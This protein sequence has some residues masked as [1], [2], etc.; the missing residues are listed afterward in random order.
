M[1]SKTQNFSLV[2]RKNTNVVVVS[3]KKKTNRKII[4]VT[5]KSSLLYK[6][7]GIVVCVFILCAAILVTQRNEINNLDA[8]NREL[9]MELK[10]V[11]DLNDEYERKLEPT[12][13]ELEKAGLYASYHEMV[14]ANTVP[15]A[16]VS[17]RPF[18][19]ANE[20]P[21]TGGGNDE[22]ITPPKKNWFRALFGE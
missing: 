19:G 21:A 20:V 15:P 3:K 11:T 22:V 12:K 10:K 6:T 9:D 17:Y 14:N 13:E 5:S 18:T 2:A 1:S 16:M 7:L 8:Q 4:V